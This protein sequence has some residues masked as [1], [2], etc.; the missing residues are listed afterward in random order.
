MP[1]LLMTAPKAPPAPVIKMMIPAELIASEYK[2]AF[3]IAMYGRN[4]MTAAKTLINKATFF[5]PMNPK[6]VATEV[7]GN[8]S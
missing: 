1:L 8:S 3:G 6:N 2:R 5:S 7:P 4:K